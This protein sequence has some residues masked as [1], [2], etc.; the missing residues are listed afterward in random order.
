MHH[1]SR[2]INLSPGAQRRTPRGQRWQSLPRKQFQSSDCIVG[3]ARNARNA[4]NPRN[5]TTAN[6]RRRPPTFGNAVKRSQC[7]HMLANDNRRSQTLSSARKRS[8]LLATPLPNVRICSQLPSTLATSP[9]L[10]YAHIN[11]LPVF[12][13]ARN[14]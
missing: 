5:A 9:R 6:A 4:R 13:N 3:N 14:A 1:F 7:S 11:T 2:A 10:A 12:V 8:E